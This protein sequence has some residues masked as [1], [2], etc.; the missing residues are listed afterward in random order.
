MTSLDHYALAK[1]AIYAAVYR[2]ETIT[3]A[4]LG[5]AAGLPA[6]SKWSLILHPMSE[7][8]TLKNEG[9]DPTLA[10]VYSNTDLSPYF[11][12]VPDGEAA[13]T[14]RLSPDRLEEYLKR[15]EAMFAYFKKKAPP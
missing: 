12:D 15:R 3:F 7:A 2:G 10:V 4:Q 6:R 8:E 9:H 13:G 5:R 11:S 1:A 14:R